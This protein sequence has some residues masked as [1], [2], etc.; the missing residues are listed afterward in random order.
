MQHISTYKYIARSTSSFPPRIPSRGRPPDNKPP[1]ELRFLASSR[2]QNT[3]ARDS[4]PQICAVAARSRESMTKSHMQLARHARMQSEQVD[5]TY[6][7][8]R[9]WG[10]QTSQAR[11]SIAVGNLYYASLD[12]NS[13]VFIYSEVYGRWITFS[14]RLMERDRDGLC[15]CAVIDWRIGSRNVRN[16][17]STN[18]RT[19]LSR[20]FECL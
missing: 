18:P 4:H 3:E 10:V 15:C 1:V 20:T 17:E 6:R 2:V 9:G 14:K 12:E 19:S 13:R 8:G 11:N 16:L 5:K 7:R